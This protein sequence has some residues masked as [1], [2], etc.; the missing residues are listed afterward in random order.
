MR[1]LR[2]IVPVLDR[3]DVCHS[4]AMQASWEGRPSSSQARITAVIEAAVAIGAGISAHSITLLAFGINSLIEL[5]SVSVL[6]WRLTVELRHD[7]SFAEAAEHTAS[8]I[9][10][11]L[12][13]ALAAYVV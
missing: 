4:R 6:I 7:R 11:A 1:A 12:L 5:A 9:S 10:V 8:R 2:I 13:F 3:P